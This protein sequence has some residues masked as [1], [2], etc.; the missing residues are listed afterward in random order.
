MR[1][2]TI[3]DGRLFLPCPGYP[4]YWFDPPLWFVGVAIGVAVV[5]V[6]VVML[7]AMSSKRRE[8]RQ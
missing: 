4:N 3:V 6:V 8:V 5:F 1:W 2:P 7:A